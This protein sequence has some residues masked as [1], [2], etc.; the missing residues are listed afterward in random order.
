MSSKHLQT[1]RLLSTLQ[2][3]LLQVR[4]MLIAL[5]KDANEAPKH[6]VDHTGTLR[7]ARTGKPITVENDD[8]E[9]EE[10]CKSSC[11]LQGASGS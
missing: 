5:W 11:R 3:Y 8:E 4:T 6:W 9:E 1:R 2:A 10:M 7:D